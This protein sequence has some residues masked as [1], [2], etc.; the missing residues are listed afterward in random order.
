MA[1][2]PE[3]PKNDTSWDVVG[4]HFKPN[5]K[6]NAQTEYCQLT[7]PQTDLCVTM[8]DSNRPLGRP[9]E[10]NVALEYIAN[11]VSNFQLVYDP[12]G[13]ENIEKLLGDPTVKALDLYINKVQK[14]AGK[15][16]DL[17]YAMSLDRNVILK[18]LSQPGCEGLRFYLCARP[19]DDTKDVVDTDPADFDISLVIVGIDCEGYDLKYNYKKKQ[20]FDQKNPLGPRKVG[21]VTLPN[22]Q[23]QSMTG[24]YVTPPYGVDNRIFS[25]NK[26]SGDKIQPPI[27]QFVLFNI[28]TGNVKPP[29]YG[30]SETDR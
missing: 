9:V 27:D 16:M 20:I 14:L 15:I 19:D 10:V 4:K 22:L 7:I 3:D 8:P 6:S 28:A 21:E 29:S 2:P 17:N 5:S 26:N 25:K 30:V 11:F 13:L 12:P 18:M 1:Q 24:E 23:M